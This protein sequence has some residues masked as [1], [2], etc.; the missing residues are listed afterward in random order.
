MWCKQTWGTKEG[1][2]PGH[3]ISHVPE[4]R[5]VWGGG[6]PGTSSRVSGAG[7]AGTPG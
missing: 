4:A 2:L 1:E 3:A 7:S 5:A 6:L